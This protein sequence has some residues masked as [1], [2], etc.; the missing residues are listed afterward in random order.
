MLAHLES[1]YLWISL[2]NKPSFNGPKFGRKMHSPAVL[3]W[4]YTNFTETWLHRNILDQAIA[5]DGLNVFCADRTQDSGKMRGGRLY[6]YI[7]DAWCSNVVKVDGQCFPDVKFWMV[8]C[9]P[10]YLPR[11]FTS[12][13]VAAVYVP[14]DTNSKNVPQELYV[15]INSHM[16]KQPNCIFIVAGDFN[17]TDL[18]TVL[19][20]FLQHV[21]TATRGNNT[22]DHVTWTSLA[23][24]KLSPALILV[25]QTTFPC[26]PCLLTPSWLKGSNHQKKVQTGEATAALQDCFECTNWHMFRDAATQENHINI[27]EYTSSVKSFTSKCVDD[28]WSQ[29]K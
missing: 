22:L 15:V 10:Y 8:R 21:H 18:R 3:Q 12:V 26:F 6:V 14:P 11:E 5:L 27:E 23:A 29:R 4:H 17:Q 28:V 16:T 7:N 13:F 20:K 2:I 1:E 19:L 25:N 9:R 24:R